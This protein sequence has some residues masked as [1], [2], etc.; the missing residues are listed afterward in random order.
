[1]KGEKLWEDEYKVKKSI[2]SKA[3]RCYHLSILEWLIG[4]IAEIV[5]KVHIRVDLRFLEKVTSLIQS[6]PKLWSE[7]M[8]LQ[9]HS[10]ALNFGFSSFNCFQE[11]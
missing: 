5:F 2:L 10:L 3:W 1:M 6:L 7:Q 8:K 9:I 4:I 11:E